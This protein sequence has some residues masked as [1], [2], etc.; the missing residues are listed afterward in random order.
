MSGPVGGC[1]DDPGLSGYLD[2]AFCTMEGSMGHDISGLISRNLNRNILSEKISVVKV[3]PRL[4]LDPLSCRARRGD[5]LRARDRPQPP[6][7]SLTAH[8]LVFSQ[9][10]NHS[11]TSQSDILSSSNR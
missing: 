6:T 2:D 4:N 9:F 11:D 7:G 1:G 8:D 3:H 5:I 10:W